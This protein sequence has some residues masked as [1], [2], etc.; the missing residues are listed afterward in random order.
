MPQQFESKRH[1]TGSRPVIDLTP[2]AGVTW[3][4]NTAGVTV[5]FIARLPSAST[6]KMSSA[7][8]ITGAWQVRYDPSPTDVDTIGLY[9][10]EVEVTSPDG[11]KITF[12]TDDPA[13]PAATGR[14]YWKINSDLDN[15]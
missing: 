7:P 10:C 5:K 4:L 14:L 2:P 9:D 6:P 1:D 13:D 12:P 15:A 3:D 11:L 8:E